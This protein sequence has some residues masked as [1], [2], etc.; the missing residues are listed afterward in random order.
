MDT[1]FRSGLIL[2]GGIALL[3]AA[4]IANSLSVHSQIIPTILLLAGG[5]MTLYALVA[6]RADLRELLRHNR[7]EQLLTTTGM[8]GVLVGL[9]WISAL[10]PIRLDMTEEKHFSLAPQTIAMLKTIDKP[11][12][13]I[14]FHDRGMRE[15]VELYEQ[16]A[17]RNSRI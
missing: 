11:V 5:A 13:I 7:G 17:S 9:I 1:S 10:Y 4:A 12:N 3:I 8:I 2:I 16:F 6:L 15:T 14:F